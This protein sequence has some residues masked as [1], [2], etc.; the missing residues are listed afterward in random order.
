MSAEQ[1]KLERQLTGRDLHE[2]AIA[3]KWGPR[4]QR[5][6]MLIGRAE[7]EEISESTRYLYGKLAAQIYA[8]Y[9]EGKA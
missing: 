2:M 9:T 4:E 8:F 1:L 3:L 5:D 7:W 6:T